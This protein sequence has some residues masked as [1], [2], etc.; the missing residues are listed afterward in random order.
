MLRQQI[1][2]KCIETIQELLENYKTNDYILQRI[3]NHI[4]NYLPKTIAN[5]NKNYIQRIN[6]NTYLSNEQQKYIQ[7]FLSKNQYYFLQHNNFF[8]EYNGQTYLIVKED[9]IIHKLLSTISKDRI[10]MQWKYKT[11]INIIKL[12]KERNLFSSIPETNTIQH[13]LNNLYPSIFHTKNTAKYFLTMIGDN[14]LKKKS[15]LI[16]LVTTK[17]KQLLNELDDIAVATIGHTT[18]THN[19]MTKYHENHSYENCRLIKINETYSNELWREILK[20]IGL[21]LLCVAAHYSNRFENSDNFIYTKLDEEL[22]LHSYY[23]KDNTQQY[24]VDTFCNDYIVEKNAFSMEWRDLHFVWKQFLSKC[25]LPNIIYS[26]SLKQMLK[27]KYNYDEEKDVFLS[28]TSAY[29]PIQQDFIKFWKNTILETKIETNVNGT[30]E[31]ISSGE[32][33]LEVDELCSL[34]K[35]WTKKTKETLLTNGNISEENVVNIIKHFFP[36]VEV[37]EDKY[38]LNV[39]CSLWVKEHDIENSIIMIKDEIIKKKN[40]VVMISFDDLYKYYNKYCSIHSIKL[41]VSKKYFEKYINKRF[42]D[43][44][45]YESFIDKINFLENNSI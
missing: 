21:D 20:K 43:Y 33:D 37:V 29:I 16:F 9:D 28:I 1:K 31:K 32:I 6:R 19:F 15:Q 26:N 12:I 24:I 17:T 38:V 40:D 8:Y 35:L 2:D 11:K 36:N 42:A 45:M 18:I 4:V 22:K 5:E 25:N 44:I 3:N 10:L 23:L 7:I 30:N 13:I 27:E 39:K 14:I 41:I 34:F